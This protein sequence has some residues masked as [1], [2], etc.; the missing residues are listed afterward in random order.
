MSTLSNVRSG[1][2]QKQSPSVRDLRSIEAAVGRLSPETLPEARS[3]RTGVSVRYVPDSSK[4]WYVFRASYGRVEKASDYIIEDG[5]YVYIAKRYARKWVN[6][7]QKKFLE[8]LIPNLLFVYTTAHKAEEYIRKT[9]S[10]SYLTYY[11]NH[12]ELVEGKKNPPLTVSCKE[13]ENFVIATCNKSE[14][15]KFVDETHCHFKGGEIVKVIDGPFMGV[16]GRVARVSGQQRV[17]VT[18]SQVGLVSTAYI[19]TAFIQVIH[20]K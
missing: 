18:L 16:E 4:R 12:F 5:T 20:N 10:L 14:H 3:S 17:V 15:L 2:S 9:P 13:M 8:P 7:K 11:Y 19:P 1:R 6:G